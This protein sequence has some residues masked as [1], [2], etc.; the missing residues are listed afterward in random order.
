MNWSALTKG[1]R[2]GMMTLGAFAAGALVMLATSAVASS[3]GSD[4]LVAEAT[5]TTTTLPT[6]LATPDCTRAP[7]RGANYEGC[8][9]RNAI[10]DASE[11]T[12]ANFRGANLDGARFRNTVLDHVDF[13]YASLHGTIFES[14]TFKTSNFTGASLEMDNV[15]A[16]ES[17]GKSI[18]LPVWNVPT[19]INVNLDDTYS[20]DLESYFDHPW[21]LTVRRP[22]M[23]MCTIPMVG[24][25]FSMSPVHLVNC[26][27]EP[28][29]WGPEFIFGN[30]LSLSDLRVM[31]LSHET[32]TRQLPLVLEDP[33]G[34][35]KTVELS[36][37]VADVTKFE[38]G[39][40][41]E[42]FVW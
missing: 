36:I 42:Y 41:G 19:H 2:Q 16:Y 7:F 14:V 32:Q 17:D 35:R 23:P 26:P 31:N 9:L 39:E 8:D 29:Q 34:R 38:E 1:G 3:G 37:T 30:D 18:G 15:S 28:L 10:F 6:R 25:G 13:S 4:E 11:L 22:N 33:F 27:S 20:F 5:T 12:N 21:N 40:P 24:D